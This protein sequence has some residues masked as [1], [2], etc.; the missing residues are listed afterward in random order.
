MSPSVTEKKMLSIAELL[1][2]YF[3]PVEE[4][5]YKD[6]EDFYNRTSGKGLKHNPDMNTGES[7]LIPVKTESVDNSNND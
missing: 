1:L 3:E 5:G 6:I 7:H 2:V 4:N